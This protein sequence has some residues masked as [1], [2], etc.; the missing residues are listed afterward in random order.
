MVGRFAPS[1]RV[2]RDPVELWISVVFW[3]ESSCKKNPDDPVQAHWFREF[4][5]LLES[6]PEWHDGEIIRTAHTH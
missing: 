1:I 3:D 2:D 6:E 4:M 5:S